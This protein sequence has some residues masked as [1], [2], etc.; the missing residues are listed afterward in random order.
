[1]SEAL[2]KFDVIIV[3]AGP[4]GIAAAV[5]A[6]EAGKSVAIVDDAPHV[7]GQ[8]WRNRGET[9]SLPGAAMWIARFHAAKVTRFH[10]TRV[11]VSPSRNELLAE[12]PDGPIRFRFN[13]LVLAT[14][15]RE[16]F[17]PFPGW[18]TPGVF[19]AGA[20]QALVKTGLPVTGKRIV[21]AGTGPLLLAVADLLK[22]K[23]AIVPMILEQTPS[24]KING[25]GISLLRTP[26][27]LIQGIA[28]RARLLGTAYATSSY[29]TRVAR[30]ATS[31]R[32]DYRRKGID[33]SIECDHLACGFNLLP[34][35]ELPQLLGCELMPEGGFVR[36][37]GRLR[38]S[39]PNV[40]AI[41]ELTGVGGVEKALLGGQLAAHALVGNESGA[42]ALERAHRA[43]MDFTRR[44]D[45][46]FALQPEVLKITTPDT[47][48]CRCEDV[49]LSAVRQAMNARDAKLQTRCGMGPCQGRVCGP[50]LQC[51]LG[52]EPPQVRPPVLPTSI[53]TLAAAGHTTD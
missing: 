27:K 18:T 41:G 20:I 15:A 8:I 32:V 44:L 43:A 31:L 30:T 21:V 49:P 5:T 47:I 34:N 13:A 16:L 22:A 38:T 3:G 39:V 25:F 50:A 48:V 40:F 28:L 23:G 4:G 1:M 26:A 12:S 11:V 10:Q 42:R 35:N 6:A 19:G 33:A 24:K 51:L 36:V 45:A 37:D 29:A 53:R 7:G 9:P 17:L 46:A 2:H 52:T 14:G